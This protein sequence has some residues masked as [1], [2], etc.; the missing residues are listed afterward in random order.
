MDKLIK[1]SQLMQ[2]IF[3]VILGLSV[4]LL[5][6]PAIANN[7]PVWW[8]DNLLNLQLQWALLSGLLIMLNWLYIKQWRMS[9]SLLLSGLIFYNLS[10]LYFPVMQTSENKHQQVTQTLT[11]AQ[12]NLNYNNPNLKQLLPKL[13]NSSFDLLVIQEASDSEHKNINALAKYYPYSFGLSKLEA[14]PSGMA[15]FSRWPIS[16]QQV[17]DLGYKSGHILEV[18]LQIGDINTPV[19][20]FALHPGS[21]RSIELWERRNQTL[22]TVANKVAHST[23]INKIVI[24]DFNSSPWTTSFKQFQHTSGLKNSAQGFGYL[25][26]WSYSAKPVLAMLSSVYID[27]HLVSP[28]F[29]VLDKHTQ[30]LA[31]SDHLMVITELAM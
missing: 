4:L 1:K 24:G 14:T 9:S 2:R 26:S 12:F 25:P 30:R 11:V 3:I 31:G 6:L 10:W 7:I 17:H 21:P 28:T 19:Q 18:I 29:K 15:I 16:E 20:L 5:L 8:L 13:G 22:A 27:H 23:F